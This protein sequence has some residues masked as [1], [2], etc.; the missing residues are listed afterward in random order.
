MN[1]TQWMW[2]RGGGA[3]GAALVLGTLAWSAP[4][5]TA[6][7]PAQGQ[8]DQ[9]VDPA[10]K[11][12]LAANGLYSRGLYKLAVA[13]YNDFLSQY[14]QHAQATAARYALAI[15]QYRL[16]DYAPA[17][18]QLHRVL[19]DVKFDQRDEA[20]AV[21]G[22]CE[23][24][25]GHLD[26]AV[27]AFD[28][29]LKQFAGSK[30]AE[31]ATLNRAQALYLQKKY[32]DAARGCDDYLSRYPSGSSRADALYFLALS[33]RAQNQNDAAVATLVQLTEKF[34]QSSHQVD[35]LLLS[36]Q[37]LEALG[38]YDAAIDAY[39][40]M[41]AAAAQTR[42]ADA[43]YSLGSVLYKAGKYDP[44]AKQ[45]STLIDD[46]STSQFVKP[47]RLQ[48]G[49]SE[50]AGGNTGPARGTLEQVVRDDPDRGADAQYGLAQC[51]I[52]DKQYQQ[53]SE[54]LDHLIGSSPQPV[55]IAQIILDHS[56]CQME[57]G[58][59]QAASDEL[60]KLRDQYKDSTQVPEATYRQAFCLHKLGKYQQSHELCQQ[61]IAQKN[62]QLAGPVAELDAE[63]LFLLAKY[64]EAKKQFAALA[65]NAK[66]DSRKLR[67]VFRQGQCDYFAAS[68][69]SAA[70]IF[71]SIASDPKVESDPELRQ[72]LLLLGDS[73]LQLGKYA[74]AAEPLRRYADLPG[75]DRS[76]AQYKLG[77]A[78]LHANQTDEARQSFS[79]A[80]EGPSDSP[81]VQRAWFE[82]G[83]IDLK[84]KTFDQASDS[85]RR[86]LAANA[87]PEVAAPAEYQLG[88]SEF[89]ARRFTQ[90]AEAWKE[91][92]A[93]YPTDK[94][95][96]DAMFQEG[97]A[98]RE[99]KQLS[100][101]VEVLEG[102]A[103]S[104]PDGEHAVKARQ[105]AAACLKELGKNDQSEQLLESLA[106]QAKGEGA[107]SVLYDLAWAQ[108]D[109]KQFSA[110]EGTYRRLL[111]EHA[112]SKLAPA[113]RTELAELLYNDKHY[114]DAS[115]LLEQ[116]VGDKDAEQKIVSMAN[117]RL[118][119][120]YQELKQ[121]GKAA[122]AFSAYSQKPDG[123]DEMN[124]SALV[125]AGLAYAQDQHY[126]K[127]EQALAR[128]LEKYPNQ[129]DA[130][131]AML[132]LG[133]VQAQQ[134]NYDGSE[135]TYRQF[136][137]KYPSS[138]FAYRAQ[139]GVAW[140]LENRKQFDE[141]RQAYQKVIAATN[142]PTAARAQFQ[143]GETFLAEGKFDK[144]V[145][146][147]LAVDDVYKYPEWAARALFEAGRAF[148]QLKQPDQAKKQYG[149]II[150]KYKDAP[151]ADMARERLKSMT[152]T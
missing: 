88:W 109:A 113:A 107:D 103:S 51:D 6:E 66:D 106:T 142:G 62:I 74:D 13:E 95:A 123:P 63:N 82:R 53:A 44:A 122:A 67:F 149:D 48:L 92:A 105:V 28:Q 138:E 128:M 98:L 150:S 30:H 69:A 5:Q 97:L 121:P 101:A 85:F 38:K 65:D 151:E 75:A 139:F 140:A 27:A 112:Q 26:E 57:L 54:R 25:Q 24:Q 8:Q 71:A 70:R 148:E 60:Q 131:V 52:A 83:Q 125:Q 32:P 129:K 141:A 3:C 64:P 146:A 117:Y 108:R 55:N 34:P 33:Q 19:D 46:Y 124:A 91:M 18:D 43:L 84:N 11:K 23:L 31:L 152:G 145:P 104:H 21:L 126:D 9:Q 59:F 99:A 81:W 86:V 115:K 132:K 22:H 4:A 15:C 12:L 136:L 93:R 41:L 78:Q 87:P 73:L 90:A 45:F 37:A 72:T 116:A 135:R 14:P 56:I 42:K 130:P 143:I 39:T 16:K 96:A 127:A 89:G 40:Q 147:L 133:E 80:T 61:A 102:Y 76:Q 7:P 118:G 1:R 119:W 49:L 77:V 47:A 35:A 114:D 100:Q 20:L 137:E 111:D 17:V 10:T 68:Y 94:L 120:C 2:R 110:A 79:R 144:A 134:N 36:G 58:K 50:L 29:L